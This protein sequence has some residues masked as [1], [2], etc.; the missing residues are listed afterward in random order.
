MPDQ[1][2]LT[3]VSSIEEPRSIFLSPIF[4]SFPR[5]WQEN[6]TQKDKIFARI[7]LAQASGDREL[8]FNGESRIWTQRLQH[9]IDSQDRQ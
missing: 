7:F 1:F 4:L 3:P 9:E 5:D 8:A 6:V 2:P